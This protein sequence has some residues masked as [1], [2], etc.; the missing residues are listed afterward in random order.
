M[1]LKVYT[2]QY[3]YGLNDRLDITVSGGTPFAPSWAMVRD[4]KMGR[5]TEKAYTEQYLKMMRESYKNN[6]QMWELLLAREQITLVCFCRGAGT[7]CHRV[8]LAQILVGLGA[9][10][11][12]EVP[13]RG[14]RELKRARG[15][16]EI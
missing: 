14:A 16:F 1:P 5:L 4:I 3:R 15:G 6:R 13:V 10:Y 11:L 8:L 7:F 2:S 12:G 9:K